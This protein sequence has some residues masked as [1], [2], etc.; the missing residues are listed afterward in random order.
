[1]VGIRR[2]RRVVFVY[3]RRRMPTGHTRIALL[4]SGVTHCGM[5]PLMSSV[6]IT[7]DQVRTALNHCL[8]LAITFHLTLAYPHYWGTGIGVLR[9]Y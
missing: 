2:R 1:V 6:L 7:H 3:P 5:N 4:S 8:T 9:I